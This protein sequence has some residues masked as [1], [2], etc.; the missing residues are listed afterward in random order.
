MN[1][2]YSRNAFDKW[3]YYQQAN[4][5][6]LFTR[7]PCSCRDGVPQ[8][9]SM[10]NIDLKRPPKRFRPLKCVAFTIGFGISGILGLSEL[11]P[12][13]AP[14]ILYTVILW[15][16]Q[17][18]DFQKPQTFNIDGFVENEKSNADMWK[19]LIRCI[20]FGFNGFDHTCVVDFISFS[21]MTREKLIGTQDVL[22]RHWCAVYWSSAVR[23][24]PKEK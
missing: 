17:R 2:W 13:G 16:K 20:V 10:T 15:R 11:N 21:N 23:C 5:R 3:K 1:W 18:L 8:R 12:W 22:K 7:S 9:G 24:A 6:V 4:T 19:A 14:C